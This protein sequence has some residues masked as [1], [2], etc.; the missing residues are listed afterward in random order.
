MNQD[1]NYK[2]PNDISRYLKGEMTDKQI[3]DFEKA[4]TKDPFLKDA[5]DGYKITGS[6]PEDL[7]IINFENINKKQN[8]KIKKYIISIAAIIT[9]FV[10]SISIMHSYLNHKPKAKN[11]IS[12]H[13]FH[14]LN[15]RNYSNNNN[16][17]TIKTK[18]NIKTYWSESL[19]LP[20][21]EL[22][23]EMIKPM[24]VKHEL[25]IENNNLQYS[26]L[27]Y[28][29]SSNHLYTYINGHKVVDYRVENRL[30][31]KNFTIPSNRFEDYSNKTNFN[32]DK[33]NN[34]YLAF[35]EQALQKYQNKDFDDAI[36]D[37]EI[38]LDQY[39]KD[40]NALFYM[41]M[42]YFKL[43]MNKEALDLMTQVSNNDINTFKEEAD[44]YTS[45][46]Y[47]EEKQFA[48]AESLLNEIVNNKG[49]YG[50]QA[51]RELSKLN[52]E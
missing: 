40:I 17:D 13:Q 34:T 20:T 44:W 39:P 16:I 31:K 27:N 2:N 37:F 25:T 32:I 21:Q 8:N 19:P 18:I 24:Y 46:I 30:N 3:K 5:V 38:I 52:M 12:K 50:A 42:C 35:L 41:S 47:K 45:I 15:N 51:A 43:D 6:L 1:N 36:N 26:D 7:K 48:Q 29:Y 22:D 14:I 4:L 10:I 49:Y 23:L 9:F 11:N 28:Y 33:I